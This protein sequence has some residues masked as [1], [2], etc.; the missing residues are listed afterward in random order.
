MTQDRRVPG[1]EYYTD[2]NESEQRRFFTVIK[3][4]AD[5]PVGT[6]FPKTIYNIEDKG[7]A[8]Y[9]VKPSQHRFFSFMTNDRKLILTNA[10]RKHSQK[11]TKIDKE[12]LKT[13]IRFKSDY[14]ERIK[15]GTYYG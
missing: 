13:A 5:A 6:I 1:F 9:A 14:A 2:L 7:H 3:T 4:I 11:M 15:R 10:Y 8:V 12:V